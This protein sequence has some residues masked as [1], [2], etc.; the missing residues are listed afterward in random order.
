MPLKEID[1]ICGR[2]TIDKI[3]IVVK[4]DTVMVEDVIMIGSN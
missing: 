1:F 4:V 3:K 2:M